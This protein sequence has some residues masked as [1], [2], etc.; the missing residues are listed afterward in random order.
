[1]AWSTHEPYGG[2]PGRMLRSG[3]MAKSMA[4]YHVMNGG[5]NDVLPRAIGMATHDASTG[6]AIRTRQTPTSKI[7][8]PL[9]LCNVIVTSSYTSGLGSSGSWTRVTLASQPSSFPATSTRAGTISRL[10]PVPVNT[11][12][13]ITSVL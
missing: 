1:M 10:W 5:T 11:S 3:T 13:A 12:A 8:G 7:S 2:L 6:S 4:P 9:D